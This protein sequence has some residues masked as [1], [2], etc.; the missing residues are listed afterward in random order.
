VKPDAP[1]V[2]GLGAEGV[3][4]GWHACLRPKSVITL[5]RPPSPKVK[6][7]SSKPLAMQA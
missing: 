7:T 2:A 1:Q 3:P 4:K 6:E 5:S